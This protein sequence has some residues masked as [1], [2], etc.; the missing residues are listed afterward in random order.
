G[1]V[2]WRNT[3]GD[4]GNYTNSRFSARQ[5]ADGGC[6]ARWT[7]SFGAGNEDVCLLKLYPNGD[8][9]W[10]RNYGAKGN[11]EACAILQTADGGYIVAGWTNKIIGALNHDL[12]V[13]KLKPNGDIDWQNTYGG[14]SSDQA[15][16]IC[17]TADGGYAVAGWSYSF[18]NGNRDLWVL[19]LHPNGDVGWQKTCG[20]SSSDQNHDIWQAADGGIVVTSYTLLRYQYDIRVLKLKPDGAVDRE[21]NYCGTYRGTSEQ[22]YS[23]QPLSDGGYIMAGCTNQSA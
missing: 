20:A 3:Y 5:T 12:W 22:A 16:A 1:R 19:K 10:Q 14:N 18:G 6:L 11:D 9:D 15:S 2:A 13:L 4:G 8:V 23:I 7:R 21:K 17:Q